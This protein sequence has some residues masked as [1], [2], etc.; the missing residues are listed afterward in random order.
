M[1]IRKVT[2]SII[3]KVIWKRWEGF[4]WRLSRC[5]AIL[6]LSCVVVQ[7]CMVLRLNEKNPQPI[8]PLPCPTPPVKLA[9]VLGAGGIKGIAHAGVLEEF[10]KAGIY[11]NLIVGCSAGA[12]IGGLYA[13]NPDVSRLKKVIM[14]STTSDFIDFSLLYSRFGVVKG[15][16]LEGFLKTHLRSRTFEELKIPLIA[17]LVDLISGEFVKLGSGP[18]IPALR[19]SS[20]FPGV[21]VP[22]YYLGRYFVDGGVINPLPVQV[23]KECGA[24]VIVAID[25]SNKI[26]HQGPINLVEVAEHAV[27]ITWKTLRSY[28][29][30]GAD[31]LI[32]M[33]FSHED[34]HTE[35][36]Y[37]RGQQ[38]A[39]KYIPAIK[40]K[41]GLPDHVLRSAHAR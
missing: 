25:V 3:R 31:F 41:L 39:R 21:F 15:L 18:L 11:P 10:A 20:A 30:K 8:P 38:E 23:A 13:D 17:V 24:E 12:L 22:V 29:E 33:D 34:A 1:E 16:A 4:K 28:A 36:I 19:G 32:R 26:N 2:G 5:G 37:K 27:D 40:K 35:E 6:L 14:N 7:G 9:L